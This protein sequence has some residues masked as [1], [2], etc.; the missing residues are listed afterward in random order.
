MLL[1]ASSK[2]DVI[3]R[4]IRALGLAAG[5]LAFSMLAIAGERSKEMS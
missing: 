1:E 2:E 5:V 3:V 4:L